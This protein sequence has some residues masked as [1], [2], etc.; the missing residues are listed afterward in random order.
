MAPAKVNLFLRV[1]E[2]RPDGYHA[3]DTEFQ[4]ISLYDTVSIRVG[5]GVETDAP[6]SEKIAVVVDGP[7]LGPLEEN[8]VWRAAHAFRQRCA[9]EEP[10]AI[11]LI[12]RIPAGAGLGGGSSD[13]AAVLL[14]LSHLVAGGREVDLSA[15]AKELGSDVPFFVGASPR[16]RGS[17]RGEVVTPLD[18][19]AGQHLVVLV[20]PVHVDTAKAYAAL[21]TSRASGRVAPPSRNDFEAV[22]T[23]SFPAVREGLR[24]LAAVGAS[25]PMLSG[26]GG[27]CFGFFPSAEAAEK[28]AAELDRQDGFRAQA[29][30]TLRSFPDPEIG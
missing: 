7:D 21:A 30:M 4:A 29:A 18:V 26:S 15:I 1:G 2:R 3:V 25:T 22:V 10:V 28:V 23:T 8:L 27:G 13:G 17:G 14:M 24:R 11:Q 16:A 19:E 12:K 6:V 9:F 5:G 20:P